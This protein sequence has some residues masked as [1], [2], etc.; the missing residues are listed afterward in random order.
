MLGC[1]GALPMHGARPDSVVES[2]TSLGVSVDKEIVQ[3]I[4]VVAKLLEAAKIMVA[5]CMQMMV[6]ACMQTGVQKSVLLIP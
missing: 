2:V 3:D 4:T 6:A 5:A 1:V